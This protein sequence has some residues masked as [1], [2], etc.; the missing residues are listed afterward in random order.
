L[1]SEELVKSLRRESELKEEYNKI[2]GQR[3][4]DMKEHENEKVEL[5]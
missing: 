2:C 3:N 1:F 5:S 4:I